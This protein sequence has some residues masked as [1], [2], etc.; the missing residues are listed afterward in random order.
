M[1]RIS[2]VVSDVD[3]TLVTTEK[4]LTQRSRSAVASLGAAG[5]GFTVISSRP[6]FGLG[7]LA[8]ALDLRLPMGAF[9]GAALVAPDRTLLD[10]RT[11]PAQT[12]RDAIDRFRS[13]SLDA[14]LF[15]TDRW[16]VE[17]AEGAYVPLEVRTIKTEP[18]IVGA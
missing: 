13:L 6:P 11:L 9:N 3:G 16:M 5:I 1:G 10:R 18:T 17:N 7:A 8:S 15:T 14:W 2:L 4:V 12:A